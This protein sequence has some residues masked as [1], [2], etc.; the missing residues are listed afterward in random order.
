ML[1]LLY[2]M[3]KWSKRASW[4]FLTVVPSFFAY[5]EFF[6]DIDESTHLPKNEIF[7]K[8]VS[9]IQPHFWLASAI[10][11]IVLV[12]SYAMAYIVIRKQPVTTGGYLKKF[13]EEKLEAHYTIRRTPQSERSM[14]NRECQ[15][16]VT[17]RKSAEEL[18]DKI[19]ELMKFNFNRDFS[20]CIKLMDV[21]SSRVTTSPGQISLLTFCR[22]GHNKV[23]RASND[24]EAV[25]LAGNSDFLSIFNGCQYFACTNLSAYVFMQKL[26][27][28]KKTPYTNTSEQYKKKQYTST[29]VVP[30]RLQNRCVI[31]YY[32]K[33]SRG[34]QLLG[35]LCI[36]CKRRCSS[37]TIKKMIPYMQ[38][39]ADNL[40]MFFDEILSA[41]CKSV[42]PRSQPKTSETPQNVLANNMGM[43]GT[44]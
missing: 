19:A 30:I 16:Y 12:V 29:I 28:S 8:I 23:D 34:D 42:T 33:D 31:N 35:F 40:Y 7:A 44:I 38:A 27:F 4:L 6:G 14:A 37:G 2:S 1:D 10:F 17:I 39:F 11:S 3:S 15:Y 21:S 22:G 18:C 41:E 36:D 24:E 5:L 32:S 25:P 26:P 43:G 20:V 9:I 13:E